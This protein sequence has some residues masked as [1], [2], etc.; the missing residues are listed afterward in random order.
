MIDTIEL[1]LPFSEKEIWEVIKSLPPDKSLGPDGFTARF[2]QVC[3]PL[4]K[5]AVMRAVGWFDSVDGRVFARLMTLS[6][7]S[8]Q[9]I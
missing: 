1:E 3:W 5:D 7:P 8:C 2:Y 4:I 9:N 6:S